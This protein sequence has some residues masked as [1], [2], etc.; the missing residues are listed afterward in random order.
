MEDYNPWNDD[1]SGEQFAREGEVVPINYSCAACGEPNATMLDLAGG[2][3]Q[4]YTDDCAICCRP[5]LIT[6]LVDPQ[7]LAV[8]I[9]NEL[10]YD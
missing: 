2:M 1:G 6:I 9:L 8:T 10:E 3:R 7:T 4:Q 5:N